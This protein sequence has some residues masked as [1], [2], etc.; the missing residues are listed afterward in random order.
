MPGRRCH[1]VRR[2]GAQDVT[3]ELLSLAQAGDDE[4]VRELTVP[5]LAELQVHC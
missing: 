4:A 2:E 3:A 1:V 5:A